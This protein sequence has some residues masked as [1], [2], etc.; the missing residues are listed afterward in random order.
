MNWP[1]SKPSGAHSSRNW[2]NS[3][4][5]ALKFRTLVLNDPSA[6]LMDIMRA[7]SK[8]SAA[9]EPFRRK[10]ILEDSIRFDETDLQ[11]EKQRLAGLQQDLAEKNRDFEQ[12]NSECS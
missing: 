11:M 1:K 8:S 5:V 3:S 9:E 2:R 10:Q 6:G 7:E 4:P 12:L